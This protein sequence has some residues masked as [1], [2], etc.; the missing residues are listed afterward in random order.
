MVLTALLVGYVASAVLLERT[1]FGLEVRLRHVYVVAILALAVAAFATR[2]RARGRRTRALALGAGV[3]LASLVAVD[4]W[5]AW[6]EEPGD[7]GVAR[8]EGRDPVVGS[9]DVAPP[10]F[11]PGS[12]NF[13]VYKPGVRLEVERYGA[14]YSTEHRRS[15]T[16]VDGVLE[17]RRVGVAIDAHGFRAQVALGQA[18]VF[19]LGD[20][21]T[22]GP[23]ITQAETWPDVLAAVLGRPVYNLGVDGASPA[24]EYLLLEHVVGTLRAP[25]R[26][27]LWMLGEGSLDGDY[28]RTRAEPGFALD[29]TV[30]GALT[31]VVP[32]L[33]RRQ[34][35]LGRLRRNDPPIAGPARPPG[36]TWEIDGVRLD[37][38]LHRSARLGAFLV[39]SRELERARQPAASVAGHPNRPRLARVF[40]DMRALASAHG[41]EVT[42][43]IAPGLPR[44]YAA[45]L[46]DAAI[47]GTAH[48]VELVRG[49]ASA[50]GFPTVDL[51]EALRPAAARELLYFRDDPRWNARGNRVAA[52]AIARL[53][54]AR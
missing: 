5:V 15:A 7:H 36:G 2:S 43:V 1:V 27:V 46:P 8:A 17:R 52:E 31:T 47:S 54:F 25:V 18:S 21:L 30:F 34:S 53:A 48:V 20:G 50:H 38:P 19:A 51:L 41:F 44:L 32:G 45:E 22:H 12:G 11:F 28:D 10:V 35:V 49:L 14:L 6:R 40:A 16:L 26:H 37:H 4:T 29:R 39:S 24:Q 3:L 23:T 9:L 42:V 33:I 13:V